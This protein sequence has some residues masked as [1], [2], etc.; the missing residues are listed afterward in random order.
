MPKPDIEA[1]DRNILEHILVYC[2]DIAEY[3]CPRIK[4]QRTI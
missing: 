2:S 3:S 4:I 1:R